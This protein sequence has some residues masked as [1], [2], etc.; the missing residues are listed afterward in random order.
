MHNRPDLV[1]PFIS[2]TDA[3]Y[4]GRALLAGAAFCA[5]FCAGLLWW[6]A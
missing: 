4:A 1:P 5:A 6:L 2:H 3:P